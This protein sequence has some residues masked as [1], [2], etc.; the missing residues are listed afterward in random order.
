[1]KPFQ[2]SLIGAALAGATLLTACGG[3][4]NSTPPLFGNTRIVNGMT[5]STGLSASINNVP[6]FSGVNFG[7]AS[8][9]RTQ[10]DGSYKVQVSSASSANSNGNITF[11]VDNVGISHD[12]IATVL[13]YGVLNSSTQN[14]FTASQ[15]INT[16]AS[17]K[18]TFQPLHSAYTASLTAPSLSVYLIA[19]GGTIVGATPLSATFAQ[20]TTSTAVANGKYEIVVTNGA[21]TLFDSGPA[22]ITLPPATTNVVQLAALDAPG[23]PNGSS[24][25]L[26]LL[27]NG[28]GTRA[29]L[30]GAN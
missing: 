12:T 22:G 28:G 11:T 27:D 10:P 18:F 4:N 29:L 13:T 19:P 9:I 25:S 16:P 24:I 3:N 20:S 8:G 7:T 21:T 30:N 14:G 1:M 23:A 26:L 6:T 17:G 15:S 2:K 5:D